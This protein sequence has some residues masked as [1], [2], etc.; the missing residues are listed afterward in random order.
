MLISVQAMHIVP[1]VKELI[2]KG[3]LEHVDTIELGGL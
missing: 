3:I 2:D 1:N